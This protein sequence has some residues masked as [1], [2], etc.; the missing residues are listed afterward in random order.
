MDCPPGNVKF[1]ITATTRVACVRDNH[2]RCV[3]TRNSPLV[4]SNEHWCDEILDEP[5]V[6]YEEP[7]VIEPEK[8]ELL[9]RLVG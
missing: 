1:A 4:F 2:H 7:R 9:L 6:W 5:F 3:N 8:S